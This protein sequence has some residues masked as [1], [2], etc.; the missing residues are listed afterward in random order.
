MLF[1]YNKLQ[2]F[3]CLMPKCVTF[4]FSV[5]LGCSIRG[6]SARND[7]YLRSSQNTHAVNKVPHPKRCSSQ[8]TRPYKF[9]I[10]GHTAHAQSLTMIRKISGHRRLKRDS[11]ETEPSVRVRTELP[12]IQ[13]DHQSLAK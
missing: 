5:A 3:V 8:F 4:Y 1:V 9:K 12:E 13:Y 10:T 11:N 2:P 6:R 7:A